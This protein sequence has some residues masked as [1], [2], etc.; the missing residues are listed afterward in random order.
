MDLETAEIIISQYYQRPCCSEK[1]EAVI[2]RTPSA[3]S[4]DSAE[5]D[6]CSAPEGRTADGVG[7]W[8]NYALAVPAFIWAAGTMAVPGPCSSHVLR[9]HAHTN[10]A[11]S[12]KFSNLREVGISVCIPAPRDSCAFYSLSALTISLGENRLD[13]VYIHRRPPLAPHSGHSPT[14]SNGRPSGCPSEAQA[15]RTAV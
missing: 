2:S 10:F 7:P 8:P 6:G 13:V 5:T 11:V 9:A 1:V 12:K 14:N 4:G 15:L 3:S